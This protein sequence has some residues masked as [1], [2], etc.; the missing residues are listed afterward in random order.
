MKRVN[1]LPEGWIWTTVVELSELIRGVSYKKFDASDRYRE[2]TV[3]I[4]RAGNIFQELVLDR[5]LVFVPE[6]LV[7]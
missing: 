4:L 1:G 3:P 6:S 2:S 5:D 7:S